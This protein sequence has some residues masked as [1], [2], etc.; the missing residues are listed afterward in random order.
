MTDKNLFWVIEDHME[1]A[2]NNCDWLKKVEANSECR[3]FSTPNEAQDT[4]EIEQPNLIVLDLLYGQSSGIQSAELGL[5]FLSFMMKNYPQLNILIYSSEPSLLQPIMKEIS[6][7][8]GG[9]VIVNKLSRRKMFVEGVVSSLNGELR[10]PKDLRG[11]VT[12]TEK[13]LE[14]L[15]LL[16]KE[17]LS[18]VN[19]AKKLN[20]SKRTAQGY[21]QR[22]KEKLNINYLDN[23]KTN[24]RVALCIEAVKR[25]LIYL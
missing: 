14:V 8:T 21:I 4:L 6:L 12:L 24:Y 25:K 20:I 3:I 2:Q 15:N 10:I 19:L 17:Y 13:E 23:K 11:E 1:V 7:H 18:D 22:L 9:F 16:C 5:N